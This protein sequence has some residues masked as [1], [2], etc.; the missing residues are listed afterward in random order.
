MFGRPFTRPV[1]PW[2]VA[3][4]V[5]PTSRHVG[6]R[7]LGTTHCVR[8]LQAFRTGKGT[9]DL[10][11]P[12]GLTTE[13]FVAAWTMKFSKPWESEVS[14]S[15]RGLGRGQPEQADGQRRSGRGLHW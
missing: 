9:R 7:E 10:T 5:P 3:G 11:G 14:D 8:A 2:T 6:A 4:L 13:Q 12:Q 15:S 1:V